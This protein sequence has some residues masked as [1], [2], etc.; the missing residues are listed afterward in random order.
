[1][2]CYCRAVVVALVLAI[3]LVI[4]VQHSNER[5]TEP[6][7]LVNALILRS[8]RQDPQDSALWIHNLQLK[9]KKEMMSTLPY[10]PNYYTMNRE[11]LSNLPF[12]PNYYKTAQ[13][14]M[15]P[16]NPSYY[17]M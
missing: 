8:Q 4:V 2:A 6:D 7:A 11:Q 16:Y 10:N 12:N 9:N 15:L 3:F 13:E 14:K 1:M 5:F 17:K